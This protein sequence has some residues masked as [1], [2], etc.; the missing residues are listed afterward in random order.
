MPKSTESVIRGGYT[1]FGLT[2]NYQLDVF[3]N[4]LDKIAQQHEKALEQRAAIKAAIGKIK[5][6]ESETEW[7]Q[8]FINDISNKIDT[9]ARFGNYSTALTTATTLA[10]DVA[11]NQELMAKERENENYENWKK[12]LDSLYLNNKVDKDTKEYF[13][14]K[15]KYSFNGTYDESGN[16]KSYSSTEYD[17]PLQKIDLS[18]LFTWVG[19]TVAE[20][21]GSSQSVTGRNIAGE[22]VPYYSDSTS[23]LTHGGSSWSRKDYDVIKQVWDEAIK[24]NPEAIAYMQQQMDVNS[25]KLSE[26]N[27]RLD[28]NTISED[29][30]YKLLDEKRR[31]EEDLYLNGDVSKPYTAQQYLVASSDKTLRAMAYNRQNSTINVSGG[32]GSRVRSDNDSNTGF[33]SLNFS[34]TSKGPSG[35]IISDRQT[36]FIDV[37]TGTD[38]STQLGQ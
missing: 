22:E 14:D 17:L 33:N 23:I 30:R 2:R 9:A 27:D 11:S 25:W 10:G 31:L 19:H 37:P 7:K 20:R 5:L 15:V 29:E 13:L 26:I 3:G 38:I 16:F 36:Y 1:P 6:H 12:S 18:G 34:P 21:S 4:A 24:R 8:N 35:E 32:G 28:S